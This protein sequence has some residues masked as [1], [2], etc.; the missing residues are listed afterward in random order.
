MKV[1]IPP[2]KLIINP[3]E[4]FKN[5]SLVKIQ[6]TRLINKKIVEINSIGPNI[7]FDFFRLST[8]INKLPINPLRI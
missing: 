8:K 1:G 6:K 5:G 3:I 4:R 2:I 7:F